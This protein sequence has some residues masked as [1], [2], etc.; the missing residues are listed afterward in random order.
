MLEL[1][2]LTEATSVCSRM[3]LVH[4][5]LSNCVCGLNPINVRTVMMS[6]LRPHA[7]VAYGRIL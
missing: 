7:L 3:L 2:P 5:A 4:E 6:S 1:T